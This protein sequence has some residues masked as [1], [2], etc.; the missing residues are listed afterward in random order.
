M[1]TVTLSSKG[2]IVIPSHVRVKANLRA[3]DALEINCIGC[4]IRLRPVAPIKV[5]TLAEL[6]GCLAKDKRETKSALV[7]PIDDDEVNVAIKARLYTEDLA[8]MQ[9][10][11]LRCN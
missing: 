11:R 5:T 8:T 1:K 3:G 10:G 2:Q 6:A 4:E 9:Y 7:A